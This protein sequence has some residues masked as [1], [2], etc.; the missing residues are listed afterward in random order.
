VAKVT[1]D[2]MMEKIGQTEIGKKYLFA[3]NLGYGTLQHKKLIKSEGLSIYH[4]KCYCLF[5]SK[6]QKSF[7][8]S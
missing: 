1:R 3:K 6:S 5:D 4:R 7:N 8:F 2:E